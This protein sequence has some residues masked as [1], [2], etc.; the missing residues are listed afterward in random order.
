M[1][2][3]YDMPENYNVSS[4]LIGCVDFFMRFRHP[5]I[6]FVLITREKSA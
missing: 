5:A 2:I 3:A 1:F 6:S 4:V